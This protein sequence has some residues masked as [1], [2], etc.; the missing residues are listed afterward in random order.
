MQVLEAERM[1]EL[2]SREAAA[3]DDLWVGSHGLLLAADSGIT[4]PALNTDDGLWRLS[5]L[6]VGDSYNMVLQLD[7]TR[8]G[9]AAILA[10]GRELAVLDGT[11]VVVMYGVLDADGELEK[12]WPLATESPYARLIAAGGKFT[13]WPV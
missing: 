3:N 7:M 9:A 4:A 2:K 11:D 8:P 10:S 5:F 1:V 13:V 6:A 12:P